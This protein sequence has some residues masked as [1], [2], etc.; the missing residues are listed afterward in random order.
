MISYMNELLNTIDAIK[1]KL[2]DQEYLDIMD[3]LKKLHNK[4]KPDWDEIF[5]KVKDT[6]PYFGA[7]FSPDLH[8]HLEAHPNELVEILAIVLNDT[9]NLVEELKES[10][11]FLA[12]AAKDVKVRHEEDYLVEALYNLRG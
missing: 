1:G 8:R 9:Q 4:K 6:S 2:M 3:S 12:I 11:T 10:I 5:D 7:H